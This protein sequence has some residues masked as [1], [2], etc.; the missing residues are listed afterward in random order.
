[1]TV[2]GPEGPIAVDTGFIV[3]NERTYP[4]FVGLLAELGV[5]TQPS[6]M[7]FG[8]ACD[9]CGIA[10]SSRGARG[11]FPDA[12]TAARPSQWRML[13]DVGALLPRRPRASSTR[14]R[15]RR[16]R[17]ATWLDERGYG[18]GVPRPLPRP[19]HVGRLVDGG[20]PDPRVPG[21]LPAPLPRQ[22][23]PHRLWQRAA[24]ARRPGRVA[25]VRR[26]ASSRR[27]R[28]GR[29]GRAIRS[30]RSQRDP[31]GVTVRTRAARAE[32]FDAVVMATHADDALRAPARRRRPRAPRPRRLRVLA[33]S[34]RAP[35]RRARPAVEPARPGLVERPTRRTAGGR[36]TR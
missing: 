17:S 30:T 10:F 1:M 20:R 3:Y 25:G 32:R 33:E 11:F 16:R 18:R 15:R 28:A 24:V 34:G 7:S 13:A 21:R 6:D 29:C 2:D 23:R 26:A 5:E 8:S 22:P 19:D 35:H 31:F 9:A 4:R 14:R 12:A 36:A 27:C